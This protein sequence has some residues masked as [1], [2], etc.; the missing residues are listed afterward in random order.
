VCV[1]IMYTHVSKC[2]NDNLL[3]L[4]QELGEGEWKK[5]AEEWIQVRYIWHIV[6]TFANTQ[7]YPHPA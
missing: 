7:R 2:K 6:R 1:Q 5:V 3:K 4:F